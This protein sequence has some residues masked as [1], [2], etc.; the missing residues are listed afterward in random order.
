M[1]GHEEVHIWSNVPGNNSQY[2]QVVFAEEAGGIS[3]FTLGSEEMW[4]N[5]NYILDLHS[6]PAMKTLVAATYSGTPTPTQQWYAKREGTDK[7]YLILNRS[8]DSCF[9]VMEPATG[10]GPDIEAIPYT[11]DLTRQ[12]WVYFETSKTNY[13]PLAE[14]IVGALDG[15][16]LDNGGQTHVALTAPPSQINSRLDAGGGDH[17]ITYTWEYS[18]DGT[19][20]TEIPAELDDE[21]DNYYKFNYSLGSIGGTDG[22]LVYIR[23]MAADGTA[24]TVYSDTIVLTLVDASTDATLSD[25]RVDGDTITGFDPGVYD[26]TIVYPEGTTTVPVVTATAT[27]VGS[28]VVI[29]DAPALPGDA[30]VVVTAE[31][32][33]TTL[34]YTLHYTIDYNWVKLH[35]V[36]DF[37]GPQVLSPWDGFDGWLV[38]HD[39]VH[40][41]GNQPG[42]PS[43]QTRIV[44]AEEAAGIKYFTI[45]TIEMWVNG[46]FILDLNNLDT[47]NLVAAEYNGTPATTQQW[48]AKRE[49]ADRH[50]LIY[51]RGNDSCFTVRE[52]GTGDG[53]DI[54]IVTG[55]PGL[56]RQQWDY[57][58]TSKPSYDPLAAYMLGDL[59]GGVLDNGGQT[60]VP[61][62]VIPNTL[63]SKFDAGGGDHNITYSW[64]YSTDGVTFVEI[65][66]ELPDERANYYQFN[67][68]FG[69][70]DVTDGTVVYIRRKAVDG[71]PTTVYS[72]TILLTVTGVGTDATLNT[73]VVGGIPVSGFSPTTFV[74]NVVLPEGT[75]EAPAVDAVLADTNATMVITDA[76]VLPGDATVVVTAEDGTT[77]NT[78]TV[79]FTVE[80]G[81]D[82]RSELVSALYPNPTRGELR[83]RLGAKAQQ[84]SLE[85]FDMT[86]KALLSRKLSNQE[87]T[88][89]LSGIGQGLYLIRVEA[90]GESFLGKVVVK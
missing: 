67:Y 25:L 58:E 65:P 21:R 75:T 72:D 2:T 7:H 68:T 69:D 81:I 80:T 48:Y 28:T 90:G 15:G 1:V 3:Y 33:V 46:N 18:F 43:Q 52:P 27:D 89:D 37:G 26:Y 5:G 22:M 40:V 16:L 17:N 20:F 54:E 24:A 66:A 11:A 39:E 41:W 64:E 61:V 47:T 32:G 49:G 51:N 82:G 88:I 79:H 12:H 9:S 59:D 50:Y 60:E 84:A 14:Y 74:Y 36:S 4:T 6:D 55:V 63:H 56:S 57:Y 13:D 83:I 45:G 44:F 71:T 76:T 8:N 10:D 31:D 77:V 62:N 86:G 23:R 29:T 35:P 87:T 53:P 70:I 19:T 38:G 85:V 73:L 42:N 30:T 34:T 78:Y